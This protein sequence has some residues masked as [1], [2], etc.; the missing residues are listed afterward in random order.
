MTRRAPLDR[1]RAVA[2]RA[3]AAV[4]AHYRAGAAVD[5]KEDG[6]PVTSADREAEALIAA[7]LDALDPSVPVVAEEAASAGAATEPG[8]G[9]FW[10][11]DPLDG[12][13]EFIAGRPEFTVNVALIEDGAPVLGVVHAP[14]LGETC[15][16]AAGGP[17]WRARGGGP[18][19]EIR[20]R[21]VPPEG[22]VVVSSRRHGDRAR[23]AALVGG[24]PVAA[25]RTLGSS[26]KFCALAAAEAD[27]YPRYGPTSEWDTAAG[28]AVLAAAGGGVATLDGAPLRYGKAGFRNPEFIARGRA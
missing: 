16:A 7:G 19:R 20:A 17:A 6:S 28:H 10:L 2:E 4:L 18:A 25:H 14:A 5:W 8:G 1:V 24:L 13:R 21:R 12:T 22:A 27:L 15:L 11:V 23:L 26:L 3:G 9:R